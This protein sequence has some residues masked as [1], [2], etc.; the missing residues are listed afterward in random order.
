MA[1]KAKTVRTG[2]VEIPDSDFDDNHIMAHISVKMP[3][4]MVND[5]KRLA[6]NPKHNGR[7]QTLMKDVLADFIASQA[8]TKKVRAG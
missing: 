4:A 2:T 3:L 1:K 7:Y 8:K 5:L 6:L